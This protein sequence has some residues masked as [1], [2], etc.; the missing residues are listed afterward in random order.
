VC[1]CVLAGVVRRGSGCWGGATCGLIK[2]N[3]L[4]QC[5]LLGLDEGNDG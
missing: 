1:T 4:L 5:E 3:T 2:V